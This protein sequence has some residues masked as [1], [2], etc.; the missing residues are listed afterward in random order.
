MNTIEALRPVNCVFQLFGLSVT[1]FCK[2]KNIPLQCV[3]KFYPLL[4]IAIRFIIFCYISNNY[5]V[6]INSKI[7]F[8]IDTIVMIGGIHFL[9]ISVLIEAFVKFRQE[10]KFM[11]NLQEIDNILLHNFNIDLETVKLRK[12]LVELLFVWICVIAFNCGFRLLTNYSTQYFPH[13]LTLVSS[14]CTASLTYFQII[15][16]TDLIRYRLHIVNQ[17]I[18]K[19]NYEQIANADDT[20]DT[21]DETHIIDQFGII[22]DLY[23]RLW[24]QTN[25]LN[26]RFKISMVLNIGN[27]FLYL[28]SGLYFIFVCLR[29]IQPSS[30][31]EFFWTD[32]TECIV[33]IFHLSMLSRA[34]QNVADE[35][36]NIAYAIHITKSDRISMKWSSFVCVTLFQIFEDSIVIYYFKKPKKLYISFQIRQFSFR[37]LHQTVQLNAFEF[38]D[39]D[40]TLIFKVISIQ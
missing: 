23:N 2:F 36:S 22:C 33:N 25:I 30:S 27:D 38:F 4:L 12:S 28:M 21:V 13:E 5:K 39:I 17:I 11:E 3:F 20:N 24:M 16:W 1:R 18:N 8:L 26:E 19:L 9:E 7:D 14:L 35:A 6:S 32:I 29:V 31:C 34:G 15:I 40:Y 10:E 37:L